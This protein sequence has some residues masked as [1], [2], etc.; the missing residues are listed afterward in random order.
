VTVQES[1]CCPAKYNCDDLSHIPKKVL[2]ISYGCGSPIDRVHIREGDVV[3]DLGSGGGIDCFIAAKYVGKTGRVIGIDMTEEMLEVARTNSIPVAENLGYKNVE[4]KHGYLEAI[5][6]E[7]QSA[8][9]V[10]SNCV[11][12]L[13]T[14]K[15]EVFKEIH[16]I[17][18]PG[19]RFAI[20]DIISDKK[21]PAE[22]RDDRQMWGECVSGALTLDQFLTLSRKAEFHGITLK[23]DYLWKQVN[24]LN[25]YSY[26]IE[27]HKAAPAEETS[28]CKTYVATYGGPFDSVSCENKVYHLGV[29]V[30][31]DEETANLLKSRPY[32]KHFN[33]TDP[34][35]EVP[36]E[37]GSCC[38]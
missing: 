37:S 22:M 35:V 20:A 5:P 6:V 33:I 18:K 10:T 29:S 25:F 17:L 36:E 4:F 38:G 31:V 27:G 13:S 1:L 8:D 32:G 11:I 14:E 30:E 16:R 3:V 9:L 34:D 7:G 15:N 24:G 23:K 26:I 28:C 19:G 12:N 21:V 2:E